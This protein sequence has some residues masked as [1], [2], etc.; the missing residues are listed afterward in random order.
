MSTD[1]NKIPDEL[2]KV[3]K[4]LLNLIVLLV[5]ALLLLPVLFYNSDSINKF[6]SASLYFASFI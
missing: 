4:T 2:I 5:F 1:R 6:F 3:I